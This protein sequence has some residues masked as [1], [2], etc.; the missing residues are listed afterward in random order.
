MVRDRQGEAD[1]ALTR[2]DWAVVREK[3]ELALAIDRRTDL[4]FVELMAEDGVWRGRSGRRNGE[5]GRD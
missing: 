1:E 3:A 4:G 2:K 5:Q